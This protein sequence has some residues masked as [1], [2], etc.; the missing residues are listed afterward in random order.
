VVDGATLVPLILA[1]FFFVAR[2]IAKGGG[3]AGG[4]GWDDYTIIISFVRTIV[5]SS[6]AILTVSQVLG[7]AIYVLNS[8]SKPTP[9]VEFDKRY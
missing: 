5:M 7:I 2:I 1:T 4:W 9:D 6:V 3:L 8:Y